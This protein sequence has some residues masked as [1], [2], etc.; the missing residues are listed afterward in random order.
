MDYKTILAPFVGVG[1]AWLASKGVAL[2]P[3]QVS[4]ISALL[5]GGLTLLAHFLHS[6]AQAPITQQGTPPHA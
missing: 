6:R 2:T 5:A 1:V 4:G 3:D